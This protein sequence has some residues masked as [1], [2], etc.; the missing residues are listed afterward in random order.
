MLKFQSYDIVF[1]EVPGEVTLAINISNCPNGCR[2]CHSPH[3]AEDTGEELDEEALAGLIEK[4]GNAITCVCF[5]GGDSDPLEVERLSAFLHGGAGG[6]PG[7]AAGRIKTAWYSGRRDLPEGC[8]LHHFD[9]IKLGPYVERAGGLDSASTNQ[10]FYRIENE[11]MVDITER[12]RRI[13]KEPG[14]G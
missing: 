5:M 1:Q 14:F 3:L 13:S 6:S 2:G 10:K 7:K 12:F 9:F 11:T 4:Y 8:V